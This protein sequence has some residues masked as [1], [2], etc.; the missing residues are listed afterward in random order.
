[1]RR[2][3]MVKVLVPSPHLQASMEAEPGTLDS[4]E[5]S[6]KEE[7]RDYSFPI[8]EKDVW[9]IWV[10]ARDSCTCLHNSLGMV[11]CGGE[12]SLAAWGHLLESGCQCVRDIHLFEV[13]FPH[14]QY[15][16]IVSDR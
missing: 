9:V 3:Q 7:D 2:V 5:R 11:C 14:G 1:M 4:V 6:D 8:C 16:N 15:E 13:I 10:W 12:G